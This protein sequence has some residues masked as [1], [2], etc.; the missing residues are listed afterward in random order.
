MNLNYAAIIID[1][2][3]SRNSTEYERFLMQEKL[4]SIVNFVNSYYKNR[5]VHGFGVAK[6]LKSNMFDLCVLY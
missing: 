1:I 6:D 2:Q 4:Y 3:H 5:I